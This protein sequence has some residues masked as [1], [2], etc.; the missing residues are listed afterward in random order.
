MAGAHKHPCSSAEGPDTDSFIELSNWGTVAPRWSVISGCHCVPDVATVLHHKKWY[1]TTTTLRFR[2][3]GQELW[4]TGTAHWSTISHL[5][6]A[7]TPSEVRAILDRT[8]TGG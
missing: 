5:M 4:R 6:T 1:S 8:R 3:T 2:Y 7:R